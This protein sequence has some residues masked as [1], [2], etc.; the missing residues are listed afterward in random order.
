MKSERSAMM[1]HLKSIM[2][3]V[4]G[5]GIED[6]NVM[7]EL[8]TQMSNHNEIWRDKRNKIESQ[9]KSLAGSKEFQKDKAQEEFDFKNFEHLLAK[10]PNGKQETGKFNEW[11]EVYEDEGARPALTYWSAWS[12]CASDPLG[13]FV[14]GEKEVSKTV[15]D[16]EDERRK[17]FVPSLTSKDLDNVLFNLK[18]DA[19]ISVMAENE[20]KNPLE[21]TSRKL[22]NELAPLYHMLS[23]KW[24]KLDAGEPRTAF[25]R[26]VEQE[27]RGYKSALYNF[28]KARKQRARQIRALT[29]S[30][31]D[32]RVKNIIVS[33]AHL[34]VGVEKSNIPVSSAAY[35]VFNS[36]LFDL[37][38]NI[39]GSQIPPDGMYITTD[40]EEFDEEDLVQKTMPPLLVGLLEHRDSLSLRER[41]FPE[42]EHSVAGLDQVFPSLFIKENMWDGFSNPLQ[43]LLE[44]D[45]LVFLQNSLF[46]ARA[47]SLL[48]INP[49]SVQDQIK[50]PEMLQNLVTNFLEKWDE[51]GDMFDNDMLSLK[52]RQNLQIQYGWTGLHFANMIRWISTIEIKT[53]AEIL[54]KDY[55]QNQSPLQYRGAQVA[56]LVEKLDNSW[57]PYRPSQQPE[58]KFSTLNTNI[59]LS[60]F[61]R[62][63]GQ[64]TYADHVQKA[65]PKL[66][67][68]HEDMLRAI[69]PSYLNAYLPPLLVQHDSQAFDEDDRKVHPMIQ[70]MSG[71]SVKNDLLDGGK[72]ASAPA[73]TIRMVQQMLEKLDLHLLQNTTSRSNAS[74][75]R[76][77]PRLQRYL[78]AIRTVPFHPDD[79][80]LPSRS[81]ASLLPRYLMA[82]DLDESNG[83]YSNPTFQKAGQVLNWYRY[84]GLLPEE[85]KF[86]WPALLRMLLLCDTDYQKLVDRTGDLAKIMGFEF[87]KYGSE[88]SPVLEHKYGYDELHI[89]DNPAMVW[90]QVSILRRRMIQSQALAEKILANLPESWIQNRE[91]ITAWIEILNRADLGDDSDE[92]LAFSFEETEDQ[93]AAVRQLLQRL[94][95]ILFEMN[96]EEK[97]SLDV[98]QSATNQASQKTRRIVYD[99]A[100]LLNEGLAQSEYMHPDFNT[101]RV[102]FE[103][104]G[105][106]DRVS[107]RPSGL[108]CLSHDNGLSVGNYGMI[109]KTTRENV[110]TSLGVIDDNKEFFTASHFG[111]NAS[112]TMVLQKAPTEEAAKQFGNVMDYLAGHTGNA[113]EYLKQTK[114]HPYVFLYNVLWLPS[115]IH[116]WTRVKNVDYIRRFQIPLSVI[117]N[118]YTDPQKTIQALKSITSEQAYRT[119]GISLPDD[120]IR[121]FEGCIRKDSKYRNMKDLI[122][123]MALR[124]QLASDKEKL[125]TEYLSD[126]EYNKLNKD[127]SRKAG[128]I[129]RDA[130]DPSDKGQADSV[131]ESEWDD[132]LGGG[133]DASGAGSGNNETLEQRGKAWFK[134]YKAWCTHIGGSKS[135]GP[136]INIIDNNRDDQAS[137]FQVTEE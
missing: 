49:Y 3:H 87:S 41:S 117:E 31:N 126:D 85:P 81:T 1:R 28:N 62:E 14:S 66:G 40:A 135:D 131:V 7:K 64:I 2:E 84:I 130:L 82:N 88:I 51:E 72:L 74:K 121:D 107:G 97:E 137:E 54:C 108:L 132:L 4:I 12:E 37:I 114:L 78:A 109:Q 100:T 129:G 55:S 136:E 19:D 46:D 23:A 89:F 95:E 134:A 13:L 22:G 42:A 9:S 27:L 113:D 86:E 24:T 48:Q 57:A 10:I 15:A 79:L 70:S 26:S 122:G 83:N 91:G 34:E 96:Q 58:F 133:S 38:L 111:P 61:L 59:D 99:F 80:L 43:C 60:N 39:I 68:W 118:H 77:N 18:L 76:M 94:Q 5:S 128:M 45:Q 125:Y 21:K 101:D 33:N 35:T 123:V 17:D 29:G 63:S 47:M 52:A 44:P 75:L 65:L 124:H 98:S 93:S 67:I 32:M 73:N 110:W 36:V 120:D 30:S 71:W 112:M 11:C 103:M 92:E 16:V 90:S 53:L 25:L 6:E 115:N 69:P 119:G 116:R 8:E 50:E 102:H 106:S 104:T 56:K 127:L 20:D 105:F